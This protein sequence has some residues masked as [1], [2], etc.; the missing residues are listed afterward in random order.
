[1]LDSSD[2]PHEAHYLK[3]DCSKA[4]MRLDWQPRW[5][6]A[7]TLGMIVAWQ[8]AWQ[9]QQDMRSLTLRQIEQYAQ[10]DIT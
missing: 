7:H 5:G 8:R 4:R 9:A 3:L 6:L 10:R 1:L 2:Q